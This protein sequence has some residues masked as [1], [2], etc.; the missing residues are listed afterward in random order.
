MD[1]KV[2]I[3]RG[4]MGLVSLVVLSFAS[5]A[6]GSAMVRGFWEVAKWGWSLFGYL[7]SGICN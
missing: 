7:P 3:I 2:M 6:V 5:V 1:K 4:L